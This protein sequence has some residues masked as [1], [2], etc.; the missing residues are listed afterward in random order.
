MK[1]TIDEIQADLEFELNQIDIR[2]KREAHR[3]ELYEAALKILI[4]ILM[5]LL[6][7]FLQLRGNAGYFVGLFEFLAVGQA[8]LL[9]DE[10]E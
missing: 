9:M 1:K 2:H 8:L 7:V 5:L 4:V 10:S 3:I 6:A